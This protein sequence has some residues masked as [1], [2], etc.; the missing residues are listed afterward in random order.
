MRAAILEEVGKPIVVDDV[1]LGSPRQGEVRVRIKATGVCHSDLSLQNGTLP[2]PLPSVIGHEGAGIVAEVGEG[3]HGI[4]PGDHVVISWVPMCGT[5]FFCSRDQAHLCAHFRTSFGRMDDG[6]S[7]LS[8]N[9]Q[10]LWHGINAATMAEECIVRDNQL[11][12]IPQEIP[13]ESAGLIGCG[14]LTGVFA[15][16]NT[17]GVRAGE[18]V[19]VIGCGGVGL[20]VIQGARL[21]GASVI[22]AIDPVPSKREAALKF[23]AT[24]VCSP[25]EADEVTKQ[26]TEGVRPDV[27]F[28]VVGKTML[29]RLAFDLVRPGGRAVMVGAAPVMDE[30]SFPAIGFLVQEKTIKGCY[31]GSCNPRRDVPKVIEWMRAGKL[32]LAGLVTHTAPLDAINDAF[33]AMQAGTTLRTVLIP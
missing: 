29:Q 8:R 26:L 1:E 10:E 3:V 21:A 12:V 33:E 16:I 7:R 24:H 22:V 5:C 2:W 19:A 15:A 20:N 25:D 32:D 31:Y 9:G 14:V 27:V 28:E 11:V 30:V 4:H 6:T 23:G 18:R 17:A 13:F